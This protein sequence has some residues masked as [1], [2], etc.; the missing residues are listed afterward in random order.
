MEHFA[1]CDTAVHC[2]GGL[3]FSPDLYGSG[4]SAGLPAPLTPIRARDQDGLCERAMRRGPDTS[5]PDRL[6]GFA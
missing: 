4:S 2:S 6:S 3:L 1:Q 5:A